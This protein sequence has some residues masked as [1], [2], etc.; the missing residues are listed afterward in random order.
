M[1]Q[2]STSFPMATREMVE[3]E[4][5]CAERYRSEAAAAQAPELTQ[6]LVCVMQRLDTL[7]SSVDNVQL[8]ASN[9]AALLEALTR[10]QAQQTESAAA[11]SAAAVTSTSTPRWVPSRQALTLVA[12]ASCVLA[13]RRARRTALRV[14]K[15][16][17]VMIPLA[18]QVLAATA[19]LA[20]HGLDAVR[21]IPLLG[22]KC[23]PCPNGA[24]ETAYCSLLCA[25]AVLGARLSA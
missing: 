4:P 20:C 1:K 15:R 3:G 7:Q 24:R 25:S 19:L 10:V 18:V 14:A 8:T 17:P 11:G 9:N 21:Q 22:P 2:I 12:I 16:A 13:H 5:S 23:V 6:L